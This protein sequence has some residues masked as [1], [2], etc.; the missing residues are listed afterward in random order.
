[1]TQMLLFPDPRPLVDRLGIDFFRQAPD[2]AG[3]YIMRDAAE[4]ALY[5]GKARNL[6]KRL[7]S[8]RVANPDRLPR[9]HLRLL[10]AVARIEIQ[11][12]ANEA[13]AVAREA[14]L[15]RSLR[16]RFNRAGTWPAPP[17]YLGWRINE[18]GLE[19]MVSEVVEPEWQYYG[20]ADGSAQRAL[21]AGAFALRASL[22]RLLWCAIH[23]LRGVADMPQGWFRGRLAQIATIPRRNAAAATFDGAA[24][25]L[26]ALFAGQ[27]D[28]FIAWIREKTCEQSHPF[29][30]A[31]RDADLEAI[32]DFSSQVRS[33]ADGQPPA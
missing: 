25:C 23:P 12:C 31:V 28:S 30:A 22:V 5:V 9:R 14:G 20:T 33:S 21:G 11:E 32:G 7:A 15:L 18:D 16:P 24:S 3:V 26:A 13:A 6:R 8:Y 1:M 2:G 19:L 17:R 4:A 10:R 27:S 29:E